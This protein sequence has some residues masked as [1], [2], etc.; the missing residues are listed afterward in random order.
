MDMDT[1][2][3][4]QDIELWKAIILCLGL[5]FVIFEMFHPGFGAPGIIGGILLIIS[6]ILISDTLLQAFILIVLIL[7]FLILILVVVI[8]SAKKGR[9]NRT[10]VLDDSLDKESGY[11]ATED[12]TYM[13][14]KEGV[15]ITVLRPA[16]LAEFDGEK[17][18]VVTEGE[19]IP[20]STLVKIIKIEGRR[21]VVRE[22]NIS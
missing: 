14:E 5:A 12:L 4:I 10:I 8:R 19:F 15:S 22:T 6:V 16:G 1:L 17:F 11:S 20:A 7:L 21:I 18:D 9:F 2:S 13:L 3:F